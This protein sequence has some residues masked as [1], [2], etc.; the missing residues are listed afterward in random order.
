MAAATDRMSVAQ[1][2]DGQLPFVPV[3][4]SGQT[5]S[6]PKRDGTQAY[7]IERQNVARP[8]CSRSLPFPTEIDRVAVFHDFGFHHFSGGEFF[9]GA[10]QHL[11]GLP[12]RRCQHSDEFGGQHVLPL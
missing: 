11:V 7:H 9:G 8:A 1:L 3:R 5:A 6:P 12:C 2:R 10:C 4:V